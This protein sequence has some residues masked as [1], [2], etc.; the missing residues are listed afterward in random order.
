MKKKMEEA[1]KGEVIFFFF[2]NWSIVD[3][4]TSLAVQWLGLSTF[5]KVGSIPGQGTK[6]LQASWCGPPKKSIVDL[7]YY[8]IILV[9]GIWHS[10]SKFL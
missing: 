2:F 3:L 5:T 9:S 7:Q 4:G 6:I 1:G 8:N 10:D